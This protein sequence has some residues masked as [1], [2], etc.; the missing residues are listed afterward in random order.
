MALDIAT[1][2]GCKRARRAGGV[3]SKLRSSLP[4]PYW[5]TAWITLHIISRL[6]VNALDMRAHCDSDRR[7]HGT[8]GRL[9]SCKFRICAGCVPPTA[10]LSW[11]TTCAEEGLE[12]LSFLQSAGEAL[13]YTTLRRLLRA[14]APAP[15]RDISAAALATLAAAAC[16]SACRFSCPEPPQGPCPWSSGHQQR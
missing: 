8:A 11:N 13:F 2:R 15:P 5:H 7:V 3:S 1:L 6:L 12:N 9:S 16:G 4:R 10:V 14:A